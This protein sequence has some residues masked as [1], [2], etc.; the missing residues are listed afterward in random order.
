KHAELLST[1]SARL[2]RPTAPP[3]ANLELDLGLDSMERVELLTALER[4]C[5]TRVAP[6]T[7]ATIFTLRA[8]IDA[9]LS[10]ER[11][12][13]GAESDTAEQPWDALLRQA[14]DDALIA[15]LRR[16]KTGRALLFFV[17][18][19][20]ARFLMFAL[21]RFRASGQEHVPARGPFIISPNHQSY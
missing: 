6:E 15:N 11:A 17:V 7:R 1:V 13:G 10:G 18:L 3:D 12:E 2:G 5:G 9:V 4:Q 14:P 21:L 8:L 19:A 20:I 16:R